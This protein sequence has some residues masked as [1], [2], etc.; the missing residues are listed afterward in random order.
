MLMT[1]SGY[2]LAVGSPIKG[3]TDGAMLFVGSGGR[4]AQSLID[5]L[6]KGDG[7]NYVTA[8]P[9]QDYA[10]SI[11]PIFHGSVQINRA[12][13]QTSLLLALYGQP[14]FVVRPLGH[15]DGVCDWDVVKLLG[16]YH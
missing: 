14:A 3:G 9:N 2:K 7:T 12:S 4:V 11:N 1:S 6:V 16:I 10:T 8:V 5:G 13:N 15:I